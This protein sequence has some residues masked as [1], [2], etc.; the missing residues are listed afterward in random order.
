MFNQFFMG[1]GG[2]VDLVGEIGEAD[3]VIG[4]SATCSLTLNSTGTLQVT[5]NP[6]SKWHLAAPITAIG[7]NYQVRVNSGQSP[8]GPALNT[9]HSLGTTRTWSVTRTNVGGST[10]ATLVVEILTADGA[11]VLDTATFIITAV[12]S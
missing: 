4:G 2:Q 11:T 6:A 9:L 1:G 5:G 8:A 10:S 7:A 12:L 3:G